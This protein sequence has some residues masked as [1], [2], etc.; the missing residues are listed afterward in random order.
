[1]SDLLLKGFRGKNGH[2]FTV[3]RYGGKDMVSLSD[4]GYHAK[5]LMGA[6]AF[7]DIEEHALAK[8]GLWEA[9]NGHLVLR[10]DETHDIE[11]L[12]R[13]ILVINPAE[14]SYWTYREHDEADIWSPKKTEAA[15][16]YFNAH[17]E[18]KP[19]HNANYGEVWAVTINNETHRMAVNNGGAG[20]GLFFTDIMGFEEDVSIDDP[21]I[22]NAKP[23]LP[24]EDNHG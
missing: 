19:W 18:E 3:A 16:E 12:G 20:Y 2:S 1:M 15:Q 5:L 14:M 9:S 13:T 6:N 4:D 7:E 24:A 8:R 10:G 23:L 11:G 21:S 22:Q 17:P